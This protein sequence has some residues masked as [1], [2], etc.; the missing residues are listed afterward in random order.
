MVSVGTVLGKLPDRLESISLADR[1]SDDEQWDA[2]TRRY[3]P[4]PPQ[5]LIDRLEDLRDDTD[6]KVAWQALSTMQKTQLEKALIKLL[7][8][9]RYRSPDEPKEL[10]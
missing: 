4:R 2:A 8:G 9:A 1:P 10:M 5:V 6:F 3:V 7:G